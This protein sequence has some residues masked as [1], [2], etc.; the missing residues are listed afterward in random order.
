MGW[1]D[2][3]NNRLCNTIEY[4]RFRSGI[5][6]KHPIIESNLFGII[7]WVVFFIFMFTGVYIVSAIMMG[8]FIA[9]LIF[10]NER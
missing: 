1:C 2:C 8:F 5:M 10:W 4:L 6:K 3:F 7:F 9:Y